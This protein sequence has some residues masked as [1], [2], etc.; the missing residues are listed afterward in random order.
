MGV[1][2]RYCISRMVRGIEKSY[3]YNHATESYD[4]VVNLE[5]ITTLI[6]NIVSQSTNCTDVLVK[7]KNELEKLI[8]EADD[9]RT[10]KV[11][12]SRW[13]EIGKMLD[14]IG[15]KEPEISDEEFNK[16]LDELPF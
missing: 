14:A 1:P 6:Q 11:L 10:K 4:I 13:N 9:K 16:M 7:R 2:T 12:M 3:D 15:Y 5:E 8:K